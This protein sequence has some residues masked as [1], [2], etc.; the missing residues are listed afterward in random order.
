LTIRRTTFRK[1]TEKA[2]DRFNYMAPLLL[3][4]LSIVAMTRA[5]L[6]HDRPSLSGATG[7]INTQPLSLADLRE[8][9]V[10]VEFWTYTCINWRRTLPYVRAWA[11]RY[12]DAGLVVIGV[13]TPEFSFEK[14]IANV[15]QAVKDLKMDFPIAIDDNYAVWKA[16][17]NE[18][19]PAPK[20]FPPVYPRSSP[21][22]GN[23]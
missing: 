20:T 23:R 14:N 19:W 4:S 16:F 2:L 21:R 18:Y 6:D 15:T 5:P 10:V 11:K 1:F 7:W 17:N 22:A 13:S 8:K 9:V 12:K 3:L